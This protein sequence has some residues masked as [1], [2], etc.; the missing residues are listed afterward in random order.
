MAGMTHLARDRVLRGLAVLAVLLAAG[1]W[2]DLGGLDTRV[3]TFWSVQVGLDVVF[4]VLCIRVVRMLPA[5]S[6]PRRFW[7]LITIGG[8]FFIA[9]DLSQTVVALRQPGLDAVAGGSQQSLLVLT[10]VAIAVLAMVT[11][12]I[13]AS[14]RRE[15]LTWW[16]DAATVLVAVAAFLWNFLATRPGS[17]GP[18]PLAVLLLSAALSL[19]AAFG[20][21]KLLIGG[22]APFSFGAG[23]TGM[24]AAT[25]AAA[26][27]AFT[28]VPTSS[29][30][31]AFAI[32][33][34]LLSDV[35][36]A[37]VPRIQELQ[38]R[39]NPDALIRRRRPYSRL[40]YLA[41]AS[42]QVLL[43]AILLR[44]QVDLR[45]WGVAVA[46]V[47]GTALVV[48]RQ[49]V[50]FADNARL[51]AS[52][53]QTTLDLRRHEQ[54][55][56]SL[57]Q[58]ASDI[59]LVIA[60]DGTLSYVS[61]ATS[62][63][64]GIPAE[65]FLGAR[66]V[67]LVHPDDAAIVARVVRAIAEG[68]A[69]VT[70]DLRAQ[71]ADGTWHWLEVISTNLLN[72]PSVE[73][74]ICN[75]RDVTEARQFGERLR[76]EATHDPLTGLAN[77]TLFDEQTRVDPAIGRAPQEQVAILTVD[78]DDFKPINDTLGHQVGDTLLSTVASRLANSARAEDTVARLGGDEF[79]ILL[80][81]AGEAVASLLAM[82]IL[83]VM[84]DPFLINGHLLYVHASIGIAIGPRRD[85]ESLLRDS[86]ASMYEAKEQGKGRYVIATHT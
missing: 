9:G 42:T 81:D 19:L 52:L 38:V 41:I 86:D 45:L 10:G 56:R 75:I 27:T 64:L 26:N 67:D 63:V 16:L 22:N 30:A 54:R 17:G 6:P 35:L 71:H 69:T 33:A 18:V 53:D 48:V 49:L 84:S 60:E 85:A 79:A 44:G 3:W 68:Q 25:L 37:A 2:F 51:L 36:L 80:P 76:Y 73:G 14:G 20:L 11:Y 66:V 23:A 74:V 55:F 59:T 62:R 5:R 32:L 1:Y 72:D 4:L 47:L 58:R 15:R 39:A 61:P 8:L 28:S 13:Q 50:T 7:R 82:R 29:S 78:L 31:L 24:A 65:A 83:D 57:V 70:C 40:P 77:R 43:I 34:H 12:P 46:V 21:T